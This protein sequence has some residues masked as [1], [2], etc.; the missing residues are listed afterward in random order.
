VSSADPAA[1]LKTILADPEFDTDWQDAAWRWLDSAWKALFAWIERLSDLE[2]T[3]LL[4]ACLAILAAIVWS[5]LSAYRESVA[6]ALKGTVDAEE[7]TRPLSPWAE[8]AERARALATE[9]RLREAARTLQQA[10]YRALAARRRLE[11]DG[12]RADW[13]WVARLGGGPEL[14][15]FTEQAQLVA[16]GVDANQDPRGLFDSLW[17]GAQTWVHA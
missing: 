11:W 1:V 2:R 3:A 17:T 16:Y 15:V 5:A 12:A 9:G 13:E 6:P 14:G 10:V 8:L 7:E 4:V